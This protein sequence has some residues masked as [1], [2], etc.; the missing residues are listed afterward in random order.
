VM[1]GRK[2]R[3]ALWTNDD[4]TGAPVA[5]PRQ[6]RQAH[7]RRG[8]D[9]SGLHPALL[10]EGELAAQDE[11]LNC[12]RLPR[13]GRQ[14]HQADEVGEQY[15]NDSSKGDHARIMP[16]QRVASSTESTDSNLADYRRLTRD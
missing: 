16:P 12:D 6:P 9:A 13:S 2:P 10:V 15:Q 5:P 7:P 4:Q 1:G 3:G 8:I 11:I 14:P